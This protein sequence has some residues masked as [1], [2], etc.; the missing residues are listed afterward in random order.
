MTCSILQL[1]QIRELT[2]GGDKYVV[3]SNDSDLVCIKDR[4]ASVGL[5]DI[6]SYMWYCRLSFSWNF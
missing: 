6:G 4:V 5:L 1:F 2:S 3:F